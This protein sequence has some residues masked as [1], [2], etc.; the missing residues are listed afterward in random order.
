M[1]TSGQASVSWAEENIRVEVKPGVGTVALNQN[2]S[3]EP[4]LSGL[5]P[6][7]GGTDVRVPEGRPFEAP[8]S[9]ASGPRAPG[10]AGEA[11]PRPWAPSVS[12]ARDLGFPFAFQLCR[13]YGSPVAT[14]CPASFPVLSRCS[15]VL[16]PARPPADHSGPHAGTS[17]TVLERA[18]TGGLS[19]P[20]AG[21]DP[22]VFQDALSMLP[23]YD[24]EHQVPAAALPPSKRP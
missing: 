11:V 12:A 8:A 21:S 2:W 17:V 3:R 6:L 20:S 13:E 14:G 9:L 4:R 7:R 23:R 16:Q 24:T 18:P 5:E 19:C 15:P 10:C 1:K 22:G